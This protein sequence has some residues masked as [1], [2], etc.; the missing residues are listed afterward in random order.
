MEAGR[1]EG[2]GGGEKE[3]IGGR[4]SGEK[5]KGRNLPCDLFW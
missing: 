4:V 5:R 2:R 1:W 3:N